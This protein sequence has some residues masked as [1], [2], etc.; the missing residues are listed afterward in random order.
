MNGLSHVPPQVR[1]WVAQLLDPAL[2]DLVARNGEASI[3]VRLSAAKGRVRRR[4][5]ITLDGGGHTEMVEPE[6]FLSPD[7]PI[8]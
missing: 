7:A 8:A 1:A 3:D 2:C 5:A 6:V 4:P